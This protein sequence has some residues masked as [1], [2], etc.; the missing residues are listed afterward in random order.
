M[1]H[2]GQQNIA[3]LSPLCFSVQPDEDFIGRPSRLSRRVT[4]RSIVIDRVLSRCMQA[5]F[6]HWVSAGWLIRP[7]PD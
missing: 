6:E 3:V 2:F 7:E 4:A 5:C 1:I